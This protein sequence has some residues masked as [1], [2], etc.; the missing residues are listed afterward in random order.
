M[1]GRLWAWL[2]ARWRT[3]A[4]LPSI[5]AKLWQSVLSRLPAA[6]W[7]REDEIERLYTLSREFLASKEFHAASGL[8][9]SN[10]IMLSI[11][12]QACLPVL[13]RGLDAYRGWVGIVVY[14]GEFIVPRYELDEDGVLHEY[15]DIVLG[16]AWE[17]GPLLIGW[18]DE[19][20]PDDSLNVVIH[21]FAHKLDMEN[22]DAD[23]L[24]R[25]PAEMSRQQWAEAFSSAYMGFCAQ[26]D[27]GLP[28][29]IDPYAAQSPA[30]FFAV[31]SEV[32]FM[33][34]PLLARCF[35]AVY[36]QLTMLYGMDP[37][38]RL[39]GSADA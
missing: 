15:E 4:A 38:A 13:Y 20:T 36:H 7:L 2:C 11:A 3:R 10:E 23:G 25:L 34:P 21:E 24:P 12:V 32:F 22:G 28:S 26:L 1:I 18:L 27:R 19:A 16:E 29:A 9:L 17:G 5:D 30:E 6:R 8:Q 39:A 35:P 14:P 37:A 31:C 33:D